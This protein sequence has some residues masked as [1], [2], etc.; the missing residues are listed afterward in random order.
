VGQR[1]ASAAVVLP[2][3]ISQFESVVARVPELARSADL[4]INILSG[5][6]TNTNYLVDTG[7]TQLVVRIGC[8]NAPVLGIDRRTEEAAITM[9][10]RGGITPEVLL[11]TQPEG[12]LVTRF[13]TDAHSLS[14]DEFTAPDMIPRL[15]ETLHDVHSLAPVAGSF[16]PHADI[17]QWMELVE[18]RGTKRPAR[19]ASLL[20]R[21]AEVPRERDSV[22]DAEMVLC[23]NDPYH[24]NF[25]DDGS[26]WLIDWEY[27]GMGDAMYDLAGIAYTLDSEGRD[28]LLRS[29]FGSVDPTKRQ[30]LEALIPV[31]VCWNVVW[32]LIESDGGIAGFDYLNLA[33]K[34]LDRLPEQR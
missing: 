1:V 21:V 18:A 19:L 29:Y 4:S 10:E 26:L 15:A 5:G 3:E 34:F 24:L 8:D 11:F 2:T 9:A 31:F 7:E 16:D 12:H 25:L 32:S 20:R 28:H 13:L 14:M 33:E 30:H 27:A 22:P 6:L 23:H 17:S